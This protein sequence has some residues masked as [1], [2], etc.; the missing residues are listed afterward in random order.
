MRKTPKPSC[1]PCRDLLVIDDKK[2]RANAFKKARSSL[3]SL[4]RLEITAQR[5]EG[6]DQELFNAWEK[7]ALKEVREVNERLREQ[8]N[9]AQE[10]HEKI[11]ALRH[12]EGIEAHLAFARVQEEEASYIAG[13]LDRKREL[14][15]I[16][17]S[18][19]KA[20]YAWLDEQDQ[21]A[22]EEAKE[23]RRQWQE[24]QRKQQ[25]KWREQWKR[26]QEELERQRQETAGS[27]P[28]AG[29]ES[30][31]EETIDADEE[32][33]FGYDLDEGN[34]PQRPAPLNRADEEQ[35]KLIYRQLVKE[36]HPDKRGQSSNGKLNSWQQR[37]WEDAK[38]ALERRDLESMNRIF[39]TAMLRLDKLQCLTIGEIQ[40][41]A[42]W[43]QISKAALQ[44][45]NR[46]RRRSPVW[47]FSGRKSLLSLYWK[48]RRGA[49]KET[50]QLRLTLLSLEWR[51]ASWKKEGAPRDQPL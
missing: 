49:D 32:E 42:R 22:R 10:R 48:L 44:E 36:L 30:P 25:E 9:Q 41:C 31:Q 39:S 43:L 2:V 45:E 23:Q 29:G 50:E 7:E 3:R 35:L 26:E 1:N 12:A 40:D 38:D 37:I 5:F 11:R 4:E 19:Q 16:W 46:D 21:K 33:F 28:A 6:E 17:E 51:E 14:E 15:A 18:R 20:Y 24:W 13:N 47:N 34:D 27:D 8:V